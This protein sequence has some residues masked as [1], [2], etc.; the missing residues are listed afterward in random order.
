M[1]GGDPTANWLLSS[2]KACL[3]SEWHCHVLK[4]WLRSLDFDWYFQFCD[5]KALE[6][7][8]G[9]EDSSGSYYIDIFFVKKHLLAVAS[10]LDSPGL[11]GSFVKANE[12]SSTTWESKMYERCKVRVRKHSS[13]GKEI[14]REEVAQLEGERIGLAR[15]THND[16]VGNH[17][18]EEFI[19]WDS[20]NKTPQENLQVFV[21]KWCADND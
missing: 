9:R 10:V 6:S 18:G 11:M 17:V 8:Q 14:G 19:K 15:N 1:K 5:S 4:K 20:F 7:R 2:S 12:R 16:C 13:R 3:R 21:H